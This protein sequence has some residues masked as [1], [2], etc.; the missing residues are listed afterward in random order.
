MDRATINAG[1]RWDWFMSGVDP[2]ALPAGTFNPAT[3]YDK[4][5]DGKN[6]LNANWSDA[7]PTGRTSTLASA[8][9]T[10]CSGT[11]RRRSGERRAL[12]ERCRP[13]RRQHHRQRP[14]EE[15]VGLMDV[16]PWRDLDGNGSPFDA[17]GRCRWANCR[18]R[19]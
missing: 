14:S 6:N 7:S 11:A 4:C 15:T 18:H 2:E 12:R 13:R 10:I 1:I 9:C 19:R 3:S 5:P 16:R 17:S 8:S